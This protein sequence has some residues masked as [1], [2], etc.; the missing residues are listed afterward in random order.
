MKQFKKFN[1]TGS[2]IQDNFDGTIYS[3]AT[4]I[5]QEFF[6]GS[7][8]L[9]VFNDT[10]YSRTT[11]KHQINIRHKKVN[12]DLI[13]HYCPYGNWSLETGLKNEITML[14]K[15]IDELNNKKR[16]GKNQ[17]IE[18]DNSIDRLS[19]LNKLYTEV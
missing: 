19:K 11:R 3:Y 7:K 8:T 9:K 5:Y 10:Y 13:L 15:R 14:T 17:A 18:L 16:L 4:P 6:V 1:S 12:A 2:L